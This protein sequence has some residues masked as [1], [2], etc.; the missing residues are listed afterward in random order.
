MHP[1]P[2]NQFLNYFILN[3][4]FQ[5]LPSGAQVEG[6]PEVTSLSAG[7][8]ISPVM[9]IN[10]NDSTQPAQ[11]T[12]SSKSAKYP[13]VSLAAPVGEL[14]IPNTLTEADFIALQ[15]EIGLNEKVNRT[16]QEFPTGITF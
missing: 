8:N 15:G 3:F 10:F 5:K 16:G 7:A 1:Y 6:F 9:S 11:L 2:F 12:I 14:V 13:Q 4:L